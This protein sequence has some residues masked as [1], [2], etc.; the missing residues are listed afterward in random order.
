MLLLWLRA[1]FRM[2][3]RFAFLASIVLLVL[4]FSVP[5]SAVS[6]PTLLWE[7]I[8]TTHFRVAYYS[9][10]YEIAVRVAELAESILTRL[11]PAVGWW[12]TEKVEISLSD[13]T[14]SANAFAGALPFDSMRMFVTA[15]DDLSPLGDVDDW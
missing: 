1:R 14:D 8:E 3:R 12:P 2:C 9:G 13:I 4:S 11:A 10:E 5:A 7:E 6:D 15:P